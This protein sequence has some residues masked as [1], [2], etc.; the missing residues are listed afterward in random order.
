MFHIY[1]EA[2]VFLGSVFWLL[3]LKLKSSDLCHPQSDL[4][5]AV[6]GLVNHYSLNLLS[7]MLVKI[8]VLIGAG[9]N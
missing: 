3:V 4:F 9:Q 6:G 1:F 7:K 2:N 5:Q 8:D